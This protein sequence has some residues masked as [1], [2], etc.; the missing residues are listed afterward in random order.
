MAVAAQVLVEFGHAVT[1]LM[2]VRWIDESTHRR[3]S[4]RLFRKDRRGLSFV[5]CASFEVME[6]EGVGVALAVDRHFDDEG[7][8]TLGSG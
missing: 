6:T 3:A 1:D 2:A 8:E 7:F 4:D 5:D